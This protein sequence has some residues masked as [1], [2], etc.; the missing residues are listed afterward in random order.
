MAEVRILPSLPQRNVDASSGSNARG[1]SVAGAKKQQIQASGILTPPGSRK[2]VKEKKSIFLGLEV[3]K[4]LHW[5]GWELGREETKSLTLKNVHTKTQKLKFRA[6]ATRFFS[7]VFPQPIFLSPGMSLTLPVTF[8]PLEEREYRDRL[9]FE[10]SEGTFAVELWAS[11]PRQQLWCPAS[12]KLP[13]CA[14]A[15]SSEACFPLRNVGEAPTSFRWEAPPPFQILPATGHLEPGGQCQVQVV[16]QPSAA[17][18]YSAPASCWLGEG[19]R[20]RQDIQLQAIAKCPQLRV[21]VGPERSE[22]ANPDGSPPILN[23]GPCPVGRTAERRLQLYNPSAV[24]A[25]FRIER[26]WGLPPPDP[27]FSCPTTTGVVPPGGQQWLPLLFQP[28]TVGETSVDSFSILLSG[29]VSQTPFKVMGSCK[30]PALVLERSSV[31][32][33]WLSLGGQRVQPLGIYNG[34]EV[35]A[36]YQFELEGPGGVFTL[37]RPWGVLPGRSRRTLRLTFRPPQPLIYFRRVACLVH[38]QEPLFL[39]VLGT[40][41]SDATKPAVLKPRHLAWHRAHLARGLTLYPPDIL[42]AMVQ[43]GRLERDPLGALRLPRQTLDEPPPPAPTPLPPLEEYL[44]GEAG[45]YPESSPPL[46][47]VE[48]LEVNFGGCPEPPEPCPLRL[49]NH[50]RGKV[51]VAWVLPAD[52]P[53][54]VTP[55]TC[56]IPPLKSTAARL[57]FQPPHPYRLYAAQLQAFALYKVL[58]DFNN[59]EQDCTICPSSCLKLRASGHGF[60]P[61][62]VHP[63]P[64]YT[65]DSPKVFPAVPAQAPAYRSLLLTNTGTTLL[66]FKLCPASLPALRVRPAA[67]SVA[68]GAHHVI[69]VSTRPQGT[70]WRQDRLTLELNA[71]PDHTQEITLLSR[72][73]SA[74]LRL[75]GSGNLCFPPAFPG[76]PST[77]SLSLHSDSRLPLA[78]QWRIPPGRADLLRVQ[79]GSG[80]VLPNQ[81]AVSPARPPL[82]SFSDSGY[83]SAN[84]QHIEIPPGRADLLRVQPGSGVVLPNQAATQVWTLT[85]AEE[86]KYLVR[87]GLWV[88]VGTASNPP[89]ASAVTRYFLRVTGEGTT[90]HLKVKEEELDFGPVLVH[91][92]EART[93]VLLNDGACALRY[94]LRVDQTLSGP[95]DPERVRRDPLALELE[96]AEGTVAARSK[97]SV[98]LIARPTRRLLYSWVIS[99]AILNRQGS[100]LGERRALCRATA[101][102]VY[103]ALA[104]LDA[105]AAGSAQGITR[106]HL[107]R[108]FSL[109]T[110]NKYLARDPTPPELLHKEPTR[111]SVQRI[112]PVN[113]TGGLDF[114]FGAAP[115]DAKPSVFLLL[116]K[117]IS[118][119][120]TTWSF[121]L[122]SDQR[123]SLDFWAEK[124]ELT[125]QELHQMR[126]QDN[127]LFSITPKAGCLDPGQEQTVELTYRHCFTG[128]D[129]L[130]V[131]L[132]VSQGREILLNFVGVTVT[133][134]R[135]LLHFSSAEHQFTPV[136]I[137]T[138]L[139]PRQIY[140][141]YNGGSV[142]V[143]FEIQTEPLRKVQEENFHHPVFSCLSPLGEVP[144]GCVAQLQWIFSPL[145]AK[146]YV[147][148]VPFRTSGGESA[149]VTFK[150]VGYDPHTLG[151][152]GAFHTLTSSDPSPGIARLTGPG[153]VAFLSQPCLCLRNIPVL[154]AVR[155]L[156]FLNNPSAGETVVFSWTSGSRS[157]AELLQVCPSMGLVAPGANAPCVVTLKASEAPC[158]YSVDLVCEVYAKRSL[159]RY[160][161]ELQAW[162]S[163]RLRQ[164]EEFTITELGLQ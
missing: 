94:R 160:Q 58:K 113:T 120:P 56:D 89:P 157:H 114:N 156:V 24:S 115:L 130:P 22:G 14:V 69:L 121:L 33:E 13:L 152:A 67:G 27:A 138:S 30:G 68:P 147:V 38:H 129:R 119:V 155:R 99:G 34:S 128:T 95:C 19:A 154:C 28:Q 84:W 148:D 109:E 143:T 46:V 39:D 36:H 57:H 93:L 10:S 81:A 107:W 65:L 110:L 97:A 59:V 118:V 100:E 74:Q 135:G 76:F 9:S 142:P 47:S 126:V 116:F 137:G 117:N 25:H 41:H 51:S 134:G 150:G 5:K 144:P 72:E 55:D 63:V 92:E 102:G 48:P 149:R 11:L 78:F 66:T 127:Q 108:L 111:H 70:A 163:E 53:F 162:E 151:A 1:S 62:L 3:N 64:Q 87:V 45:S 8:R 42:S 124:M 37:D 26:S 112:P 4:C 17:L 82:L 103:P 106:T 161:E 125:S 40:C 141:L 85:P 61:G 43:E 2:R 133:P 140:E 18:A 98:R 153:Q 88:W 32:F 49:T 101:T 15:E 159:A 80:V 122:P 104:V 91:E 31:N 132:K 21:I 20:R 73:E 123:I 145:E 6:P 29:N 23:F 52:G 79:P 96:Q 86:A 105:Y 90:G 44:A 16:F 136:A 75:E 164:E 146:T 77:R 83:N 35:P 7:T 12:V 71:C 131:L 139:P 60:R 54:R 158:F 50:S